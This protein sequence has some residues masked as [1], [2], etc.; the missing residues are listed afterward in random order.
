MTRALQF[1]GRIEPVKMGRATHHMIRLPDRVTAA[2]AQQGAR[3]VE[4]HTGGQMLDRAI[5][6]APGATGHCLWVGRAF[7]A[8]LGV[9][10]GEPLKI[11]LRPTP[12]SG[13]GHGG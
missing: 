3:R 9:Q 2:L 8:R 13:R 5:R 1:T 4:M 6:P 10:P 7:V 11:A 12:A